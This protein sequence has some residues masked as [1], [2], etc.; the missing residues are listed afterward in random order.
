MNEDNDG[1]IRR[2]KRIA[3][4]DSRTQLY[5]ILSDEIEKEESES[6]VASS[7]KSTTNQIKKK[8]YKADNKPESSNSGTLFDTGLKAV[9]IVGATTVDDDVSGSS[10]VC[11]LVRYETGQF[12]L[13]LNTVAH[14]YCPLL[15]I[16]FLE[17]RISFK[18]DIEPPEDL[19]HALFSSSSSQL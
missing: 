15:V 13:V 3:A 7:K 12:E 19:M 10:D 1:N 2:S 18:E 8:F 5:D 6:I 11:Y 14:K 17:S 9:T 4:K 16:N